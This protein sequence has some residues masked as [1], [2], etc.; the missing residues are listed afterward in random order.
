MSV[1]PSVEAPSGEAARGGLL[2]VPLL[3][4][5]IMLPFPIRRIISFILNYL[6]IW[7]L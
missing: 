5:R 4:G 3:P 6:F 1:T 7:K 2:S